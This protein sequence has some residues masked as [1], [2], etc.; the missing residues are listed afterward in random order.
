MTRSLSD[1][2]ASTPV[3]LACLV[4]VASLAACSSLDRITSGDKVD[5]KAQAKQTTGLDVPPDLTQLP[6]DTR[7]AGGTVS[8][9]QLASQ[10][11]AQRPLGAAPNTVAVAKAGEA[12]F[13][14]LGNSRWIHS[15][16]TP[17]ELWPQ[18]KAFW[19]ERGLQVESEDPAVGVMET[20]WAENRAKLPQDFIRKSIGTILDSIYS[21]GERDKY[22]TRVERSPNGGTDI[23]I[24]HRGMIEVYTNS[25]KDDTAWQPRPADPELESIMLSRLLLKLGGKEDAAQAVA[26]NQP[27]PQ[28]FE[29]RPAPTPRSLADVPNSIQLNEGFDRAWRRVGQSLDRHGFTIEDRD[30]KQGLFFLRYADPNQ[31]GKDEPGF[32]SRLFGSDKATASVRYRVA[33]KSEGERSTVVILDDKG[34]QQTNEMAKRI[35]QLL[36]ED[37][38]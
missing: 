3:R 17:E 21:T 28:G 18:L 38:R 24:A 15:N 7:P 33:V 2:C 29:S 35:L 8:A 10:P 11:T 20:N 1:T 6:R 36:L 31:A 34:Q 13:Q 22:R 32:W 14:R 16:L 9:A 5:Y 30:R 4:A 23:Y 19:G 37:L 26:A 12:E 27:V 25:Q